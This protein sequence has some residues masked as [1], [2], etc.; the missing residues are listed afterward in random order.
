MAIV[1]V[2]GTILRIEVIE[3]TFVDML[4]TIR[5][6]GHVQFKAKKIRTEPTNYILIKVSTNMMLAC[7]QTHILVI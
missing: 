7:H 2:V 3:M 1:H 5:A 4:A 6:G